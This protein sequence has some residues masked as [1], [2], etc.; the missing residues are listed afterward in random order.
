MEN[1][2]KI[3]DSIKKNN[4]NSENTNAMAMKSYEGI[5]WLTTSSYGGQGTKILRNG[6]LINSKIRKIDL[7][8]WKQWK[9]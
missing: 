5:F 8:Q 2:R 6:G 3:R 9:V 4:K 1:N 7:K